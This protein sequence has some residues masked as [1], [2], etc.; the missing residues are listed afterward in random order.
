MDRLLS[1][2][3]EEHVLTDAMFLMLRDLKHL[4]RRRETLLWTFVMPVIFFYF[5]GNVAGGYGRIDEADPIA[6]VKPAGSGFLADELV[7]RLE[8]RHFRIVHQD[9]FFRQL[10]IPADFTASV[11]AGRPMLVEFKRY[12]SGINT[13]YDQLRIN[14]AVYELLGDLGA[15][16]SRGVAPSPEAFADVAKQVRP[17]SFEVTSAGKRKMAPIGF[18]Q[19]V[20]GVLVMFVLLVMFTVGGVTILVERRQGILL[21]LASSPM[22]RSMIVLAKWGARAL[23]GFTQITVAMITGTI[24]FKVH[25]G[26]HLGA[27]M[28]VLAA[29]ASLAALLGLLLGNVARSEGQV[30]G[31]GVVASNVMAALGGCWWPIEITPQWTQRIASVFPTGWAMDALHRLMSFGDSPAAVI[32]H[33]VAFV[34]LSLIAAWVLARKF[35]FQ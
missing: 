23:L 3:P 5:I 4:L 19:A 9:E 21:R 25:W 2:H 24:L 20:P 26:E 16:S 27:I 34:A 10:R 11:L 35:R 7:K 13:D 33:I 12:G 18:E 1:G 32:P 22:P 30:I 6:V 28:L 31:M 17:V 29:Y 14:R 8:L 15:M